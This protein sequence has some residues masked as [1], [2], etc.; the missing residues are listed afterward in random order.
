MWWQS[1]DSMLLTNYSQVSN[2]EGIS[3]SSF[4]NANQVLSTVDWLDLAV[5]HL[6]KY[7]KHFATWGNDG[8][9]GLSIQNRVAEIFEQYIESVALESCHSA[10]SSTA[11]QSAVQSTIAILPLRVSSTEDTYASRI[12]RLQT[13]ATIASLWNGGFQRAVVVGV[14]ERERIAAENAFRL[15][16]TH[17]ATRPM[18]LEY[19]QINELTKKD[20]KNVPGVPRAALVRFQKIVRQHRAM[21]KN[22]TKTNNGTSS[23]LG[24]DPSRWQHIYYTE[25]D[26]LLH[27]R[28]EAV[29]SLSNE[30]NRGNLINAHRLNLLP[31]IQQFS[32][33][34]E[35]ANTSIATK[36]EGQLLP[37]MANFAA[38]HQ[39]DHVAGDACC[40]Q[41]KFFPSN[42]DNP[43][44]RVSPRKITKCRT[45]WVY[46]G[47]SKTGPSY[48]NWSS[49]LEKHKLLV[50]HPFLSLERGTGLPLAYSGQ[51][52]CVP[53]RGPAAT[54][55]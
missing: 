37:N 55:V 26:L 40:D 20:L 29:P 48:G 6:S 46:C 41:G 5:E 24:A 35:N 42:V 52:V 50:T 51:R 36:M 47:F 18:E 39:L 16:K 1:F 49:I 34:Y 12:I 53:K 9:I 30:L 31:H 13:A 17:L 21:K 25:P 32:D 33:I 54:C 8:E 15:L 28:P 27:I 45:N 43:N 22:K 38:I 2:L 3:F 19:A 10:S 7:A 4:K 11:K 44:K 14:S 23:W